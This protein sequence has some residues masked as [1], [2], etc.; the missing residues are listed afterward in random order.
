MSAVDAHHDQ[1]RYAW[2]FVSPDGETTLAGIDTGEIG[3][4]GRLRRVAGFWGDLERSDRP[5]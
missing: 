5:V 4:D 2:E 1:F 3:R